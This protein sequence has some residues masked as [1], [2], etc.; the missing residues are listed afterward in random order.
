MR[1]EGPQTVALGRARKSGV[2]Q[3][4]DSRRAIHHR[5]VIH[6][7][8]KVSI[9]P[10]K[11]RGRAAWWSKSTWKFAR[12]VRDGHADARVVTVDFGHVAVTART[13]VTPAFDNVQSTYAEHQDMI[14]LSMRCY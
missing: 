12:L 8:S 13:V 11:A 14:E 10:L 4:F 2:G 9:L 1:Y 3:A 7:H 6:C 5:R